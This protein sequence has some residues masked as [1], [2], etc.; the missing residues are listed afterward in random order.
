MSFHS[1]LQ[2]LRS[3]LTPGR[4]QPH[5]RP[6]GSRRAATHRLN[7]EVLEG[8]LTPSFTWA[9]SFPVSGAM[10]T[11]DFNNDGHLDLA[12]NAGD[13]LLGDGNGG[14]VAG[15][16]FA[17]GACPRSPISTTTAIS[18]WRWSTGAAK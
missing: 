6:R 8:R 1:W 4:G 18:T 12:T 3:A 2:N 15:S 17:A 5:H 7:L 16:P 11:A 13:L 9:G 14:F 10:V